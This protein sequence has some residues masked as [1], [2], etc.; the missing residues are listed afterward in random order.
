MGSPLHFGRR[1][2]CAQ[3]GWVTDV[4]C[5][6]VGPGTWGRSRWWV[7]KSGGPHHAPAAEPVGGIGMTCWFGDLWS[8]R[9]F[10]MPG[11]DLAARG[12]PQARHDVL[13]VALHGARRDDQ[14]RTDLAAGQPFRD[15][16]RDLLLAI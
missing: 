4:I 15:E 16:G 3:R 13:D 6:T 7:R 8:E 10:D 5:L 14:R 2:E 9:L 12:E 1:V 11:S